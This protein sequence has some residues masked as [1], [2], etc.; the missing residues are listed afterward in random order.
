MYSS[1]FP[2]LATLTIRVPI[3]GCL[4]ALNHTLGAVTVV[5]LSEFLMIVTV[6]RARQSNPT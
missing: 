4:I 1:S 5:V 2:V 3:I 6:L